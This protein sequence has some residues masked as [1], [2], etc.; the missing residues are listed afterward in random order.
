[1]EKSVRAAMHVVINAEW[2][3]TM[4][5]PS[6][7][8]MEMM[9]CYLLEDRR[10][11]ETRERRI[12]GRCCWRRKA[13]KLFFRQLHVHCVK[14]PRQGKAHEGETRHHSAS[15]IKQLRFSAMDAVRDEYNFPSPS[16]PSVVVN[17]SGGSCCS[18]A[19]STVD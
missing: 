18:P 15:D 3:V 13:W 4:P 1:M 12:N 2:F 9:R 16:S 8:L 14:G 17:G 11:Q 19:C 5:E 7:V 6:R 10:V